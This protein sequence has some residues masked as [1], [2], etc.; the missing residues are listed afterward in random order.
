[1]SA[2]AGL[3]LEMHAAPPHY[4]GAAL[5]DAIKANQVAMA[6]LDGIVKH[7]FVPM[8]RCGLFNH[9]PVTQPDAYLNQADIPA[10]RA[11][12]RD[13]SEQSTVLLKN[14]DNVLPLDN[15]TGRKIAVIGNA[16]NPV[17]ASGA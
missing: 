11:L 13:I 4:F 6:R 10:H 16:P 2:N 12:A 7:I 3:D 17:G 5:G 15:G 9:P 14:K 8:F 1:P